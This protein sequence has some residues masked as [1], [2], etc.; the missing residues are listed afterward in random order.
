MSPPNVL[1]TRASAQ[2]YVPPVTRPLVAS[3]HDFRRRQATEVRSS[4]GEL[5]VS[6][7]ISG[8]IP[9]EGRVDDT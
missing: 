9:K 8:P 7:A 5:S 1:L 3:L 2:L 6:P 4:L